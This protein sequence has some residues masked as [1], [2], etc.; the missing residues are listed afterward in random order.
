[1]PRHDGMAGPLIIPTIYDSR[2]SPSGACQLGQYLE[3]ERPERFVEDDPANADDAGSQLSIREAWQSIPYGCCRF[4]LAV[5][6]H[7]I[8]GTPGGLRACTLHGSFGLRGVGKGKGWE[9]QKQAGC[10]ATARGGRRPNE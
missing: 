1:V 6:R 8:Y 7:I 3:E 4:L 5:F 9:I 10:S 2:R